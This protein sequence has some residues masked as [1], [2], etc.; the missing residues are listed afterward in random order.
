[1][2]DHVK[3][4][5]RSTAVVL[6]LAGGLLLAA[7]TLV[8]VADAPD[9]AARQAPADPALAAPT[10][11]RAPGE[12]A[13][14]PADVAPAEVAPTATRAQP[15]AGGASRPAPP[16]EVRRR[17]APELLAGWPDA[18]VCVGDP[19]VDRSVRRWRE[20]VDRTPVDVDFIGVPLVEVLEALSR[21]TGLP[22]VVPAELRELVA[23]SLAYLKLRRIPL[24]HAL[25]LL[26]ESS[27]TVGGHGWRLTPEGVL[28]TQ[29]DGGR[30]PG[31]EVVPDE[32][33]TGSGSA[34]SIRP[35]ATTDTRLEEPRTDETT[36][37]RSMTLA[38]AVDRLA[39]RLGLVALADPELD[40]ELLV[41][42][43]VDLRG[44]PVRQALES[45]CRPHDLVFTIDADKVEIRRGADAR[46][47]AAERE[48][49]ERAWSAF[50]RDVLDAPAGLN[51]GTLPE[52]AR[53][54]EARGVPVVLD[55]AAA[56]SAIH[57]PAAV[58]DPLRL[59]CERVSLAAGAT[60]T[61]S[62]PVPDPDD[63]AARP[64]LVWRGSCDAREAFL[65]G[66]R[67]YLRG[68][69][70][71]AAKDGA[72]RLET[73]AWQRARRLTSPSWQDVRQL[74]TD[75]EGTRLRALLTRLVGSV[76]A[77]DGAHHVDG[78]RAE[79]G[80]VDRFGALAGWLAVYGG[81]C[82]HPNDGPGVEP[83]RDA[84]CTPCARRWA[85]SLA[86]WLATDPAPAGH[87]CAA[88]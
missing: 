69:A 53:Q 52:L 65:D 63:P 77:V 54:L 79:A 24:S 50:E 41:P 1:M 75:D 15:A 58:A 12:V 27:I 56:A 42:P 13:V 34:R 64:G 86:A 61:A 14:A 25:T 47:E 72:E 4:G 81:S 32:R 3:P 48:R 31:P 22:I 80:R 5:A 67:V 49:L 71:E 38:E 11:D 57:V 7:R 30:G 29:C 82:E 87:P 85:T 88:R 43:D 17:T 26:I 78:V 19:R 68:E 44:V 33:L 8:L 18:P 10:S 37:W 84:A 59:V 60:W 20:L 70:S 23:E 2:S 36:D 55:E 35:D 28:L 39:A 74:R 46:A 62:L 45:L 9:P 51:G 40:A 16:A 6:T 73:R 21:R 83:P 66:L 76:A